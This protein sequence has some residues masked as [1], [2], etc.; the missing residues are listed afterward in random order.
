M[1]APDPQE[2]EAQDP[3]SAVPSAGA[4]GAVGARG[5]VGADERDDQDEQW[6]SL[7]MRLTDYGIGIAIAVI[8]TPLIGFVI[9]M[10]ASG[11]FRTWVL[12]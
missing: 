2:S 12:E 8:L 5:E 1:P 9:L 7:G 3:G 10:A 6:D 4:T 11:T